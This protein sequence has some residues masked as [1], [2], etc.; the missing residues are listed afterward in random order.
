ML[1]RLEGDR[2][3]S[4]APGKVGLEKLGEGCWKE[5]RRDPHGASPPD[6]LD[7]PYGSRSTFTVCAAQKFPRFE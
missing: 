3:G 2:C 7:L 6:N 5:I 4:S 1:S